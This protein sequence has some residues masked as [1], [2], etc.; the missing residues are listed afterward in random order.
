MRA[1]KVIGPVF[2]LA[3]GLSLA[4][5]VYERATD[6]ERGLQREEEEQMVLAARDR[7]TQTLALSA[8]AE[9]VDPLAPNR[10][11][12]KVYIYPSDG[13]WEVSGYYRRNV[14]AAWMPWLMR[15]DAERMHLLKLS[16]D[17]PGVDDLAANDPLITLQ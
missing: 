8:A 4:W 6:P 17:D 16:S 13:I 3:V 14:Q 5:I 2:A 1:Q 15:L 10:V 12:G 7:L 11:A 9:V